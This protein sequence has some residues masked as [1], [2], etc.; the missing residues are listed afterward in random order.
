MLLVAAAAAL[1]G[2]GCGSSANTPSATTTATT[3]TTVTPGLSNPRV[4]LRDRF[5]G[6]LQ[7]GTGSL[8]GA[9]DMVEVRL[10]APGITGNRRLSL[11]IVTTGCPAGA[12]CVHLSGRLRGQLRE[13]HALPDVGRRYAVEASG[14]LG[15]V[16][17]M[18][19][20]GTVAGTGN[21]NFGFESLLLTLTGKD[22]SARLTGRSGRV[23]SFTSP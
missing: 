22:G 11:W 20:A 14:S 18:T 9:R 12:K 13:V 7:S 3:A 1:L 21:I 8:A 17:V 5:V 19:A 23:P 4:P 16:G 10:Q 2:S 6:T 15:P